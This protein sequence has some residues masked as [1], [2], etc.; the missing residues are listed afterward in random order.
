MNNPIDPKDIID[1]TDDLLSDINQANLKFVDKTNQLVS[2]VNQSLKK[3]D[4]FNAELEKEEQK[5]L[6]KINS[7]TLNYLAKSQ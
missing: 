5:S 1:Q 2:S 4:K 6:A 7:Q 3:V